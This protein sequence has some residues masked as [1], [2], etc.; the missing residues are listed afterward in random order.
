MQTTSKYLPGTILF[1]LCVILSLFVYKDYGVAWDE[2]AQRDMGKVSYD[3]IT[4]HDRQLET[5]LE[6]DHGTGFEIPLIAIEKTLGLADSRDIYLMRHLVTHLFFLVGCFFGYVLCYRLFR[7]NLIACIGFLMFV[8]HPRIFA[9]SFFNTKDI[10]FLSMFLISLCFIQAAFDKNRWYWYALAGA[11]CG[12][13][14]GIRILGVILVC[15]VCVCLLIDIVSAICKKNKAGRTIVNA[16]VFVVVF[17]LSLYATFPTLWGSPLKSFVEVF[18]SLSHFRW[19]GG[20][21]FGG[22]LIMADNLPWTYIPVWVAITMPIL[23]LALGITGILWLLTDFVKK[24]KDFLLNTR[25]RNF[26]IYIACFLAPIL[27]IIFFKSVVYD[28]WRHV[29]FV[30][31]AFVLLSLYAVDKLFKSK[32]M[33]MVL[34]AITVQFISVAYFIIKNHPNQQVYFNGLV[35]H[36]LEAIRYSYDQDYWF[37]SMRQ[38]LEYILANDQRDP[39]RVHCPL[40]DPKLVEYNRAILPH[41]KRSRLTIA[42][43]GEADYIVVNFRDHIEDYPY[44]VYYEVRVN[45]S[46]VMR[47]Y[48]M[49]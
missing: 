33:T 20:V 1:I 39:I 9:H 2:F 16:T 36:K 41:D 29:Y 26:V 46:A 5:Y 32:A 4:T 40:L 45:N 19:I 43:A 30:Y 38:G 25:Q 7:N 10:P 35:S 48:K 13:A 31:P 28:D 47:V 22:E 44:E 14:T 18:E 12:Y 21:L 27:A 15:I 11:A 8:F 34:I 49:R 3:Y 42:N 17:C 37:C 23:W 24:P 6:R